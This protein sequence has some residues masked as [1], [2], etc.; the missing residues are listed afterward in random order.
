M[1]KNEKEESKSAVVVSCAV[2]QLS[3]VHVIPASQTKKQQQNFDI[4]Q[5]AQ[6]DIRNILMRPVKA[7]E[8]GQL[9]YDK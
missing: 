9:F 7:T 1:K 8:Y 5:F 4:M 2:R 6:N 3:L